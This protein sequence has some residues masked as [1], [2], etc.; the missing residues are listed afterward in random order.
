MAPSAAALRA[1]TALVGIVLTSAVCPAYA[2]P[3][4]VPETWG[5]DL[6]SRQRL[7]GSWGGIRDDLGKKGVVLDLDLILTPQGVLTGGRDTGAEFWAT[8]STR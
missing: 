7:T 3:V 6:A 8:P 2:Q 4:A 5:G 1:V